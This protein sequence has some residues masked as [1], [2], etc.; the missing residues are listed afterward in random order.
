MISTIISAARLGIL[1][2]QAA[3]VAQLG[4]AGGILE[5]NDAYRQITG[6][7]REELLGHSMKSFIHQDDYPTRRLIE[8][9]YAGRQPAGER[10]RCTDGNYV[11][12]CRR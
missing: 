7:A 2:V 12:S 3:N 9:L 6:F 5:C 11:W 4:Y 1:V 8:E 10:H